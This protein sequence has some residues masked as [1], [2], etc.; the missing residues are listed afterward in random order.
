MRVGAPL[1]GDD[2][3]F[4]EFAGVVGVF[5]LGYAGEGADVAGAADGVDDGFGAV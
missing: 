4:E 5:Y 2:A 1:D 3:V